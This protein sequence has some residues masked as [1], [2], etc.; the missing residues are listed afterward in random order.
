MGLGNK[1]HCAGEG[2]QQCISQWYFQELIFIISL[3]L[4]FTFSFLVFFYDPVSTYVYYIE[5]NV[6]L[7]DE[8]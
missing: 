2:H 8:R 6:R 1:N 7:T 4:P 5:Y 3:P